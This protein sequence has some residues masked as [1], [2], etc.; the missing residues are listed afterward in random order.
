M[1]AYP[2]VESGAGGAEETSAGV[3]ELSDLGSEEVMLIVR[4]GG[5]REFKRVFGL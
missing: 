1:I 3:Y 5:D 4:I 2:E